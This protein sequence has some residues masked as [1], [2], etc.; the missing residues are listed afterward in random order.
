MKIKSQ[1]TFLWL[2]V[3]AAAVIF[4]LALSG[5]MLI[6]Y[7]WPGELVSPTFYLFNPLRDL[8]PEKAGQD[9]L[10]RLMEHGP[11]DPNL[12]GVVGK[13]SERELAY[14]LKIW[15]LVRRS[16]DGQAEILFYRTSRDDDEDFGSYLTLDVRQER[17]E[18]RVVDLFA[19]Y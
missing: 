7:T 10:K 6:D 12:W 11:C 1:K 17:G 9:F 18:W 4:G 5:P 13:Y 3:G 15:K 14:P 8:G 19:I 2:S 16:R